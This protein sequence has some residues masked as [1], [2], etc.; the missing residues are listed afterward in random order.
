M[1]MIDYWKFV[2]LQ[3]YANF[4]GRAGRAQFWWFVLASY[5]IAAVLF[6]IALIMGAIAGGLGVLFFL[7]L[8]G[9]EIAIIIPSIAVGIRRLH[10]TDKSGWWLLIA[11]IPFGFIVLLV[12]YIMEGTS[13]TNSHGEPDPGLVA[14][15]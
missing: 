13:G 10:D 14:A 11:L 1:V 15:A 3:N 2:V 8:G 5:I 9:Y 7:I 6:V 4:S 12:F